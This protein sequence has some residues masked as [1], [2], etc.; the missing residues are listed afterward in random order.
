M[1]DFKLNHVK[2]K[3]LFWLNLQ[4][5]DK[6]RV[7]KSRVVPKKAPSVVQKSSSRKKSIKQQIIKPEMLT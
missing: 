7:V 5:S 6:G 2:S 4:T 1:I 3:I